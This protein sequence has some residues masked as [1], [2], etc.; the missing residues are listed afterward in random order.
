MYT[1]HVISWHSW[2][3]NTTYQSLAWTNVNVV[4]VFGSIQK[5]WRWCRW[6]AVHFGVTNCWSGG[7]IIWSVAGLLTTK[8]GSN[9]KGLCGRDFCPWPLWLLFEFLHGPQNIPQHSLRLWTPTI[10]PE[11]RSQNLVNLWAET[12]LRLFGKSWRPKIF[13]QQRFGQNFE[14]VL[15]NVLTLVICCIL[16]FWVKIYCPDAWYQA[17]AAMMSS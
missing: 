13:E 10:S 17:D 8:A 16:D 6:N 9:E 2:P 5:F 14:T 11:R 1:I 7:V 12:C 4:C 3:W 15:Q